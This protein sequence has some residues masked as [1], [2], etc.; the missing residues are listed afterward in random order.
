MSANQDSPAAPAAAD[1]LTLR[2]KVARAI[3]NHEKGWP[4][5]A[6]GDASNEDVV[7]YYRMAD[8]ALE[9]VRARELALRQALELV[10]ST[11]E[12]YARIN[13]LSGSAVWTNIAREALGK[14]FDAASEQG[15]K[16]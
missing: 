16:G 7:R 5:L 1:G 6:L 11:S 9:P 2:D 10:I 15:E 4:R 3:Y 8:A 13:N 12:D 14:H